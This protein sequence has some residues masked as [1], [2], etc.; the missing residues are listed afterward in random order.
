MDPEIKRLLE[1][2]RAFAKDNHEMLRTMRRNQ[3]I[4]FWARIIFWVAIIILP[5][6]FLQ[7]YVDLL[8]SGAE[9]QQVLNLYQGQY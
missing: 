7:P 3:W 1:E 8:P 2:T 4:A 5:L 9:L 6:Y